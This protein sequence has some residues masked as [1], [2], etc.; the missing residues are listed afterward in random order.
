MRVYDYRIEERYDF[1]E[2]MYVIMLF[3]NI[4]LLKKNMFLSHL[5]GFYG[6]A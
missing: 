6:L 2:M 3:K 5:K 4:M 1:D